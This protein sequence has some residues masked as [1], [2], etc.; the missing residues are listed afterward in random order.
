M[1]LASLDRDW[2]GW[3]SGVSSF[4][5]YPVWIMAGR[6]VSLSECERPIGVYMLHVSTAHI[7]VAWTSGK[8]SYI[9]L[10]EKSTHQLNIASFRTE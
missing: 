1:V 10:V 6:Y 4:E 5:S 8:F 9:S 3:L 7:A 2:W